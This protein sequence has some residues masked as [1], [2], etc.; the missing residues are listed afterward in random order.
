MAKRT[1]DTLVCDRCR[2]EQ[3]LDRA[4]D[5]TGWGLVSHGVEKLLSDRKPPI[6]GS[7]NNPGDLCPGCVEQLWA[8]WQEA[9]SPVD[10]PAP[11]IVKPHV[12]KP[13]TLVER[14]MAVQDAAGAL[15]D[16]ADLT[17]TRLQDAGI[18]PQ[19]DV[20]G[21]IH[22]GCEEQAARLVTMIAERLFL[23]GESDET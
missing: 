14:K 19:I 11:Q 21:P 4:V 10:Q 8:W 1:L 13:F 3:P 20:L 6:I 18:L 15:I 16:R 23:T 2:K 5:A 9:K 17:I 22:D 7:P 12:R